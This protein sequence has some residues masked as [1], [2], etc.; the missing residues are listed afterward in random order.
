EYAR[1][2]GRPIILPVGT[3]IAV[4]LSSKDV[5]H[6][7]FLPNFRVK[8]D[9]LP[10]MYGRLN[11]TAVAEA[12]STKQLRLD[13]PDLIAHA[14]RSAAIEKQKAAGAR[15]GAPDVREVLDDQPYRMR[16]D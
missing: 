2:P 14:Q 10:G 16:I 9:A 8:L 7:F 6:D 13:D 4:R 11:F 3:P 15:T 12:Q 1:N 5:I